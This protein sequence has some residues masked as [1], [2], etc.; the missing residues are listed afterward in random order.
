M[1]AVTAGR[2]L[3]GKVAAVTGAASGIGFASAKAMADAGAHVVLH[4]RDEKALDKACAAIGAQASPLVLDLLDTKQCASLLARTLAIAGQL[5]IFHANAGLY[6]GGDLVDADP[7]AIDR[8]L[9][10][11]VNVVMKNV[12]NVLPHMIERGTS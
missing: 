7:D 5:D 11:T 10:L 6:V 1:P 9:N 2:E 12:H 4:H 8:M 3:H